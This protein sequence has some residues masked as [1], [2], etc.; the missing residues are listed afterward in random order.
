MAFVWQPPAAWR[1]LFV[2]GRFLPGE[3]TD[4]RKHA[5]IRS[6]HSRTYTQ[7]THASE[8][9]RRREAPT[10]RH[11]VGMLATGRHNATPYQTQA[12]MPAATVRQRSRQQRQQRRV[13]PG[14]A[15]WQRQAEHY[16][17]QRKLCQR[18]HAP[19]RGQARHAIIV[20]RVTVAC[21]SRS[22]SSSS[23]GRYSSSRLGGD[24]DNSRNCRN[25]GSPT[26]AQQQHSQRA[27]RAKRALEQDPQAAAVAREQRAGVGA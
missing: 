2:L 3:S 16:K 24:G 14:R 5:D 15:G 8:A 25:G 20:A 6:H 4:V 27:R 12:K 10:K 19:T 13:P 21:R 9:P 7:T 26:A 22:G 23:G 17:R 1:H 18:T 11:G